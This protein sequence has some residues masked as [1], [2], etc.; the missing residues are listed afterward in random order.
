VLNAFEKL[1]RDP[2]PLKQLKATRKPAKT[3]PKSDAKVLNV[4]SRSGGDAGKLS[5]F[6]PTP[7]GLL[8]GG[9]R[10][11]TP[12]AAF[13][14]SKLGHLLPP[15]EAQIASS[16]ALLKTL[17]DPAL[18]GAA[19]KDLGSKKSFKSRGL[20]LNGAS[21]EE[22]KKAR[23]LHLTQLRMDQDS[24]FR[25]IIERCAR[26]GITLTHNVG[27]GMTDT[28]GFADALNAL[29]RGCAPEVHAEAK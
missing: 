22:A 15:A 23:M 8:V 7:G 16:G 5:N 10:F 18:T 1:L 3:K 14:A 9:R 11:S 13:Q 24:G 27:R 28:V 21:W 12:E 29:V 17:Q 26:E 4:T 20:R 25:A 19:A 2:R 6:F